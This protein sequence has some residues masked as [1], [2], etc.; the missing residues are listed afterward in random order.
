VL[1]RLQR[2]IPGFHRY[3][4]LISGAAGGMVGAGAYVSPAAWLPTKPRVRIVDA[5]YYDNYGVDIA[6][7]WLH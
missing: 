6:A 4:R 3:V 7:H 1:T 2:E 5:G